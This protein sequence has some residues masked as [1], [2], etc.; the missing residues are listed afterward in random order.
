MKKEEVAKEVVKRIQT[1]KQNQTNSVKIYTARRNDITRSRSLDQLEGILLQ[2][3][4]QTIA[5][6][7]LS[8]HS[9]FN[10]FDRFDELP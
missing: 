5:Q 1:K 4:A 6:R 10:I 7:Q 2:D 3:R 8:A 9:I